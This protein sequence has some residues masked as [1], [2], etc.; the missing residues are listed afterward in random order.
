MVRAVDHFEEWPL[1]QVT[2]DISVIN[3]DCKTTS[4]LCD[5]ITS[6]FNVNILVMECYTLLLKFVLRIWLLIRTSSFA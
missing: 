4:H 3:H 1:I 5:M 2:R 6:A